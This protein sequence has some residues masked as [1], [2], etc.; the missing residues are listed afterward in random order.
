MHHLPVS[1]YEKIQFE[2]RIYFS[3]QLIHCKK[4]PEETP[5]AGVVANAKPDILEI[6]QKDVNSVDAKVSV[7]KIMNAIVRLANVNARKTT[8]DIN[9]TSVRYVKIY[10][11]QF[12]VKSSP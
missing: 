7:R 11:I 9:A 12:Q 10:F 8:M 3:I 6:Q 1:L 5:K 4:F 2:N